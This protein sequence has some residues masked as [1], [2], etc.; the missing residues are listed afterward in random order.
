MLNNPWT[1]IKSSLS[2]QFTHKPA[3]NEDGSILAKQISCSNQNGLKKR[4]R[5][6]TVR[7]WNVR[8]MKCPMMNHLWTIRWWNILESL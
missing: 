6:R 4:L 5:W 8:V 7:W 1:G 2:S 3:W